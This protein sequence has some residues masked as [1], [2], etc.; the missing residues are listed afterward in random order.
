M[1]SETI[2]RNAY[3]DEFQRTILREAENRYN[4]ELMDEEERMLFLDRI[5]R[6]RRKL[7]L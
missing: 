7:G 3:R 6:L 5:K 4:H 2:Q 1:D